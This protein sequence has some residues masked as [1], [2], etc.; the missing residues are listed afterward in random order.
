LKACTCTYGCTSSGTC[1][2]SPSP[3]PSPAPYPSPYPSPYPTYPSP[4]PT[5]PTYTPTRSPTPNTRK[6]TKGCWCLNSIIDDSRLSML[7]NYKK[8]RN[9]TIEHILHY[10]DT[11]SGI[12]YKLP[13]TE[14]ILTEDHGVWLNG[15][16]MQAKMISDDRVMCHGLTSFMTDNNGVYIGDYKISDYPVMSRLNVE[17]I[18]QYKDLIK[19]LNMNYDQVL[20][21]QLYELLM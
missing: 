14:V 15:E 9:S 12:G 2:T 16:Y 1:S 8:I 5:Y 4:Y 13:N 6:K 18:I 11:F 10:D 7:M 20:T 19:I 21:K 3:I 17:T